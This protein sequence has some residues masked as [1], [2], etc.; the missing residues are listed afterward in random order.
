[1]GLFFKIEPR[2]GQNFDTKVRFF[3]ELK[4]EFQNNFFFQGVLSSG[5]LV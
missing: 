2:K 3:D 5:V 4:K 1:L